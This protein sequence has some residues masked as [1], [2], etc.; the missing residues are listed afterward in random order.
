M[1]PL[2]LED[3]EEIPWESLLFVIGEIT[4]GGRV[5]DDLDRRCLMSM[6]NIVLSPGI[7]EED[8][9][10][11]DAGIY[12]PPNDG[13][14][15]TYTDY[16]DSL[17]LKDEPE[18]FGMHQNTNINFQLQESDRI[19]TTVLNIQPRMSSSA[20]GKSPD[21]IIIEKCAEIQEKLP[22]ILSRTDGKKE[23]FKTDS[24]GLLPSLS[25]VLV[26]EM[27]RFNKLLQVMEASLEDLVKAI[28]GFIVMS[29]E[30]D[31][32]YNALTNGVVPP[33]WEK[34]AY[35]S[36]KP[37][38]T[39]FIDLIERVKFM[40][41][42]LTK[43]E[44]SCF[45]MSGFF[46]PQGFM[47]GVLQT[48]ARKEQIAIDKLNFSFKILD[49]EPDQIEESPESGVYIYG[50]FFDGARWDDESGTITDQHPGILYDKAPVFWFE[51]MEEYKPDPEEYSCPVYKTSVRA[52]VL[53]TTGQSTNYILSVE[54]PTKQAPSHWIRRG[55]ALLCQL[56]D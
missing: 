49:E 41:G 29:E 22:G 45:W 19:V 43:G 14:L 38:A 31:N 3:Q 35:P 12:Y 21:E 11:S 2:L 55:A 46:F 56:N 18:V 42:W 24:K 9:K 52:G 54:V 40:G 25:T 13:N 32:M 23:M 47:T 34:V 27:E 39:W 51:P 44:P 10:F 30:L 15:K 8:Y 50:L 1:L 7:Q 33:N 6:L 5:T 37:F 28:Q 17:P 53:S 20:G 36:L 26:Q 4:Y 48:H 16:I